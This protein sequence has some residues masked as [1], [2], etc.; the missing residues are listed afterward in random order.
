MGTTCW[1]PLQMSPAACRAQIPLHTAAA[2]PLPGAA[3]VRFC[4]RSQRWR[5]SSMTLQTTLQPRWGLAVWPPGPCTPSIKANDSLLKKA[6]P[7][8]RNTLSGA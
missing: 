6:Q 4:S 2:A 1:P 3:S 5:L 7:A 8:P